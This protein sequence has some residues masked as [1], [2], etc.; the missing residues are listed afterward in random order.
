[1]PRKK[2][3]E[4]KKVG[5]IM[6]PDEILIPG[7]D[8]IYDVEH[9]TEEIMRPKEM[10]MELQILNWLRDKFKQGCVMYATDVKAPILEPVIGENGREAWAS[11]LT[12][13][14]MRGKKVELE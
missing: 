3:K 10:S 13:R 4:P 2:E 8:S 9:V 14:P 6:N 5:Q 1:M 12:I 7:A 11:G